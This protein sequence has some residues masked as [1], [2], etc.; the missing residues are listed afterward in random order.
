MLQY[1]LVKAGNILMTETLAPERNTGFNLDA[2]LD[3]VLGL[4]VMDILA[5][6]PAEPVIM[7]GNTLQAGT[8]RRTTILDDGFRQHDFESD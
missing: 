6:P 7:P 4:T 8:C 2:E 5:M 1:E 3:Q